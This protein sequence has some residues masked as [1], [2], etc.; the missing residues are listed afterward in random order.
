LGR[1]TKW[2]AKGMLA[3]AYMMMGGT[4]NLSWL[5]RIEDILTLSP[6]GLLTG[7]NAYSIFSV[8]PMKEQ[9]NYFCCT[10]QRR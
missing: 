3:K 9:G 10:I 5:K 2:A 1:A 4:N 7:A 6:H 8:L